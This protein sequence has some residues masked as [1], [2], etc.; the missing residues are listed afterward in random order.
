M[1]TRSTP[2]VAALPA[3]FDDL[4]PSGETVDFELHHDSGSL[5]RGLTT[6]EA[7]SAILH[8]LS[9]AQLLGSGFFEATL[10]Q[11]PAATFLRAITH[12]DPA[13]IRVDGAPWRSEQL[14]AD[15]WA[16]TFGPVLE[17]HR[18][19]ARLGNGPGLLFQR[20]GTRTRIE[21][22]LR[23]VDPDPATPEALPLLA[24]FAELADE[25]L[26]DALARRARGG[27]W[28]AWV[29][30]AA[31]H[32]LGRGRLASEWVAAR[33][34]TRTVDE[35]TRLLLLAITSSIDELGEL[36]AEPAP[37]DATWA[38]AATALL[39]KREEIAAISGVLSE[40]A[41]G[42]WARCEGPLAALDQLGEEWVQTATL[43]EGPEAS[44][45]LLF[46]LARL[47]DTGQLDPTG[48]LPWWFIPCFST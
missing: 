48:D 1:T 40:A 13:D 37:D 35:V 22:L 24:W 14:E 25:E 17:E 45:W 26:S 43:W 8:P 20:S 47:E 6:A 34:A 10:E 3:P 36:E 21:P 23:R 33:A 9:A 31:T 5:A 27:R 29:A 4:E 32:R 19:L 18:V 15:V 12:L 46:A 39:V 44:P 28:S 16:V 11:K 7:E 2:S 38:D 41:P 42:L 30:G